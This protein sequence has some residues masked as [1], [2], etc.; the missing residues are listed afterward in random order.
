MQE[1]PSDSRRDDESDDKRQESIA[2]APL[3]PERVRQELE[4]I[5]ADTGIQR[6]LV[7]GTPTHLTL[8]YA[9]PRA[10]CIALLETLS[11]RE[12]TVSYIAKKILP[13]SHFGFVVNPHSIQTSLGRAGGARA[14]AT[15]LSAEK[16]WSKVGVLAR[17]RVMALARRI[18]AEADQR[19]EPKREIEPAVKEEIPTSNFSDALLGIAARHS[20]AEGKI[21]GPKDRSTLSYGWPRALTVAVL[22]H[23]AGTMPGVSQFTHVVAQMAR[24]DVVLESISLRQHIVSAGSVVDVVHELAREEGWPAVS[25]AARGDLLRLARNIAK[26]IVG[27][28]NDT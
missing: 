8:S 15:A 1:M 28:T 20:I 18:V 26:E 11:K 10:V 27:S 4:A 2:E 24:Y 5:I 21:R 6:H 13:L 3:T 14:Y 19:A 9:W 17:E 22:E 23:M 25:R 12:I 16:N 7:L